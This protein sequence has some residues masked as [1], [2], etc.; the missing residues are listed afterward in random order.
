[1][2]KRFVGSPAIAMRAIRNYQIGV[3]GGRTNGGG[4]NALLGKCK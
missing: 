4:A 2:G 3:I 1:M